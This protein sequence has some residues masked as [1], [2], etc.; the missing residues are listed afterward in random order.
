MIKQVIT[1]T[2]IAFSWSIVEASAEPMF[3]K[4]PLII[5]FDTKQESINTFLN[6]PL[7]SDALSRELISAIIDKVAPIIAPLSLVQNLIS[8]RIIFDDCRLLNHTDFKK[9]Y[10]KYNAF[11]TDIAIVQNTCKTMYEQYINNDPRLPY[12]LPDD[13]IS[14]RL[15]VP[16]IINFTEKEWLVKKMGDICLLIPREYLKNWATLEQAN[17]IDKQRTTK[18]LSAEEKKLGLKFEHTQTVSGSFFNTFVD[19][20][21][22]ENGGEQL[23]SA[24]RALFIPVVDYQVLIKNEAVRI[25]QWYVYI[26]GHGSRTKSN[27]AGIETTIT[28][29]RKELESIKDQLKREKEYA[30]AEN[31]RLIEFGLDYQLIDRELCKSAKLK[32][33]YE[34]GKKLALAIRYA[35]NP[36]LGQIAGLSL[37]HFTELAVYFNDMLNTRFLYVMSC[38]A[39]GTHLEEPYKWGGKSL[40][41]NYIVASQSLTEESTFV[42]GTYKQLFQKAKFNNKYVVSPAFEPFFDNL[43]KSV[44]VRAEK[45][46]IFNSFVNA[47]AYAAG[48]FDEAGKIV[49]PL[50]SKININNLVWM[51]APGTDW[52]S[53]VSFRE[54]VVIINRMLVERYKAEATAMPFYIQKKALLLLDTEEINVPLVID[55]LNGDLPQMISIMS[56]RATHRFLEKTVVFGSLIDF[57]NMILREDNTHSGSYEPSKEFFF[58]D[59]LCK[60]GGA[61]GTKAYH[62]VLV[63]KHKDQ[64]KKF[65]HKVY[66]QDANTDQYYVYEWNIT[67]STFKKEFDKK[68]GKEITSEAWGKVLK[69]F[70][71]LEKELKVKFDLLFKEYD[72]LKDAYTASFKAAQNR[73]DLGESLRIYQEISKIDP[74][75]AEN[76]LA[77]YPATQQIKIRQIQDAIRE[78]SIEKLVDLRLRLQAL[79]K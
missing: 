19:S 65:F 66:L 27:V 69:E 36:V 29:E 6:T 2:L 74:L 7:F 10:E 13:S 52:F 18:E 35:R 48:F 59:V 30:C 24:L 79:S 47:T 4:K 20:S 5:L 46:E 31:L 67:E 23:I 75:V 43:L 54:Y 51:R 63:I 21:I 50:V 73:R 78:A 11:K 64:D 26:S 44:P 42:L 1:Y 28:T 76:I 33:L 68:A 39:A 12:S 16:Y 61:L 37:P 17:Y 38:F 45:K 72:Y 25:P 40:M 62:K 22:V 77:S 49:N 58:T 34:V 55:K 41:L 14:L 70:N 15:F 9:K 53:F 8:R 60:A 56:G 3:E 71:S 57:I 32:P